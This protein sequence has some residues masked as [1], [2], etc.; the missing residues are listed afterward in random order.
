MK[1]RIL[2]FT[3]IVLTCSTAFAADQFEA[4]RAKLKSAQKLGVLRD[5]K[6]DRGSEPTVVV[7][8]TFF[9]L[10]FAAKQRF[11]STLNCFLTTGKNDACLSFDVTEWRNGTTVGRYSACRLTMKS[12]KN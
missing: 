3:I 7:G 9:E 12:A 5:L 11:A 10:D 2:A 1:N 4:C 8:P 6:M